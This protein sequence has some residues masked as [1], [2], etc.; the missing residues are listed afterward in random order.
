MSDAFMFAGG[1]ITGLVLA[2]VILAIAFCTFTVR[3][4]RENLDE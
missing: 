2:I 3:Y 4:I 1:I